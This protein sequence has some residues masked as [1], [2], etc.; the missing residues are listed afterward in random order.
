[1]GWRHANLQL[2]EFSI[3]R[4]KPNML[5]RSLLTHLATVLAITLATSHVFGADPAPA[6]PPM[7]G[8]PAPASPPISGDPAPAGPP[9]S[10]ASDPAP[11][12]PPMSIAS[13]PAPASPPGSSDPIL[14]IDMP[15]VIANDPAPA[16]AP[17]STET[18]PL[19]SVVDSTA[20]A[21]GKPF[22]GVGFRDPSNTKVT[23]LWS[24]STALKLGIQLGDNIV[25]IN[26]SPVGNLAQI[27]D[28]LSEMSVGDE[29]SVTIIRG[30][31]SPVSVGPMPLGA[32]Y[33]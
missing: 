23:T 32:S 11:A 15:A 13:D 6:N 16:G 22:L 9:M 24:N 7:G 27:R 17:G 25:S 5:K 26:A 30:D 19:P 14:L 10:I 2:T 20:D 12:S 29:V 18:T 1:M 3:P 33:K 21:S 8:D 31:S 28:V 4:A